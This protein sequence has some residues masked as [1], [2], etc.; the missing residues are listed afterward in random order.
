MVHE[1]SALP[2]LIEGSDHAIEYPKSHVVHWVSIPFQLALG[3]AILCTG[4]QVEH[5]G[6]VSVDACLHVRSDDRRYRR[7]DE[8]VEV[9]GIALGSGPE[10]SALDCPGDQSTGGIIGVE[11]DNP[12]NTIWN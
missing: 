4:V 7:S 2:L 10:Q 3:F 1:R 6:L 11:G 5:T 9:A 8:G 12:R